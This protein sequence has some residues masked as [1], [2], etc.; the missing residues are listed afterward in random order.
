[1][2]LFTGLGTDTMVQEVLLFCT[3]P[4]WCCRFCCFRMLVLSEDHSSV[5]SVTRC[6]S[7]AIRLSVVSFGA[8]DAALV[9]LFDLLDN[10]DCPDHGGI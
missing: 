7:L 2:S 10:L 6:S 5:G 1:M 4:S 8:I 3:R 9:F